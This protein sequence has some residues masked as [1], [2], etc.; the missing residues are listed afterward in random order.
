MKKEST[1][2]L[3][4]QYCGGFTLTEMMVVMVIILILAAIMLYIYRQVL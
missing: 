1:K 4:R 3:A 2:G